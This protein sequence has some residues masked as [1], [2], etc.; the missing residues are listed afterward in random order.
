VI[1]LAE[2][3]DIPYEEASAK[4]RDFLAAKSRDE[5]QQAFVADVKN[6]SKIEVLF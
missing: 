6:K 3:R 2:R 5:R 1:K 4:I